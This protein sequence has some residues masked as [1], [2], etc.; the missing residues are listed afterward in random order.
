VLSAYGKKDGATVLGAQLR[1]VGD[2]RLEVFGKEALATDEAAREALEGHEAFLLVKPDGTNASLLFRKD[3][4]PLFK[5]VLQ[6]VVST[7][8]LTVPAGAGAEW[9]TEEHGLF[10]R[11]TVRYERSAEGLVRTATSYASL[12]AFPPGTM[13]G[14]T[15]KTFGTGHVALADDG[16]LTSFDDEETVLATGPKTNAHSFEGRFTVRATLLRKE[17]FEPPTTLD[18][19]PAALDDL[20]PGARI[21]AETLAARGVEQVA[22]GIDETTLLATLAG[23]AG[24]AGLERGFVQRAVAFLQV[25]PEH[26]AKLAELFEQSDV[27]TPGKLLI[28]DVLA[29]AG[30]KE[31]QAAL[32]TALASRVA[33]EDARSFT[34]MVQRLGL[35]AHPD[36][37]SIAFLRKEL[38]AAPAAVKDVRYGTL[39]ALGAAA[40]SLDASD[41]AA[42]AAAARVR[43]ELRQARTEGDKAAAIVALGNAHRSEDVARI[44]AYAKDDASSVRASVARALV[45]S[46]GDEAR[47]VLV[48][49]V[50]DA[51][52]DVAVTA[53]NGLARQPATAA[54]LTALTTLVQSDRLPPGSESAL[55]EYAARQVGTGN[56]AALRSMLQGV[57]PR[58]SNEL[59]AKIQY[60]LENLR[61]G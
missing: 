25:H 53:L 32:R 31:A 54:D 51:S 50:G 52:S 39:Y 42:Q 20:L 18:L 4:P 14:V 21:S 38:D 8:A 44:V 5:A 15:Q 36:A 55:V 28:L 57:L 30:N 45:H 48:D 43:S 35:L 24:G 26:C 49:L 37:E 19:D 11:R 2:H 10:G 40:G 1:A 17:A 9:T 46:E 7:L 60:I 33:H 27:K 58:A 16:T 23:F 13:A 3:A 47:R 29:S 6:Q 56:D 41:P 22:A 12:D 59:G 61:N 34:M